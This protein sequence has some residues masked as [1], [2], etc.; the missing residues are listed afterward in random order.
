MYLVDI[1]GL[2][3]DHVWVVGYNRQNGDSQILYY[4]GTA[5]REK[6]YLDFSEWWPDN[7]NPD[8]LDGAVQTVWAYGDT[9]YFGTRHGVWKESVTTR[10]GSMVSFTDLGMEIF[11]IRRI[12]GNGCNDVFVVGNKGEVV[13]FNGRNWQVIQEG[14]PTYEIRSIDVKDD[15]I[16]LVGHDNN[17]RALTVRGYR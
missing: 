9:V 2:D 12:R 3:E 17:L 16:L 10:K 5:W 11:W 15:M 6:Y 4:D 7:V 1:W 8:T 13:H 14:N